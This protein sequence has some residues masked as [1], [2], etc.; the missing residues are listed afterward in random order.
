MQARREESMCLMDGSCVDIVD[1]VE[2]GNL[3]DNNLDSRR[4]MLDKSAADSDSDMIIMI[5]EMFASGAVE[6][7]R[8]ADAKVLSLGLGAGYINSYLHYNFPNM[9]ITTVELDP[10]ML[11]IAKKWYALDEDY[12]HRVIIDDGLNYMKCAAESGIQYEVVHLDI[13]TTDPDAKSLCPTDIFFTEE[14]VWVLSKLI[15]E[16]AERD[17]SMVRS[18]RQKKGTEGK[19]V[20]KARSVKNGFSFKN[21][22]DDIGTDMSEERPPPDIGNNSTPKPFDPNLVMKAMEESGAQQ[23]LATA[24]NMSCEHKATLH[25]NLSELQVEG[26]VTQR[27]GECRTQAESE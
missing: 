10:A 14:P 25:S 16:R 9:D 19:V 4:W 13:C 27:L 18:L 5:E 15:S 6:I 20:Y 17:L 21:H 1:R 12:R 23:K 22:G 7:R 26:D 2:N 24:C 3:N 11:R 8:D